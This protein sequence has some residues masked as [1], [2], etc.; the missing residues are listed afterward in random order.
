[1]VKNFSDFLFLNGR[2]NVYLLTMKNISSL[3]SPPVPLA[4][5]YIVEDL[6]E[7]SAALKPS[8]IRFL[9][10]ELKSHGTS[11]EAVELH[12]SFSIGNRVIIL[13]EAVTID[14]CWIYCPHEKKIR[15]I[16]LQKK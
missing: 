12:V 2:L 14:E 6:M 16:R 9:L 8:D 13:T 1:M 4:W 15:K 3:E 10:Q 7:M 5:E 11:A